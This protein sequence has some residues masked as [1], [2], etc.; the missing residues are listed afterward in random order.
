MNKNKEPGADR[1]IVP[2]EPLDPQ[3]A[4][5]DHQRP[6]HNQMVAVSVQP[7]GSAEAQF[8]Q[9]LP[10]EQLHKAI[11]G[12]MQL[13]LRNLD[14]QGKEL[15]QADADKARGHQRSMK[16]LDMTAANDRAD[17]WIVALIIVGVAVFVGFAVAAHKYDVAEKIVYTVVGAVAGYVAGRAKGKARSEE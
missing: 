13:Q 4:A 10:P 6:S 1:V 7:P 17:R 3:L 9:G 8:L 16:Q 12:S 14:L 11:E 2:I 15:D 5:A